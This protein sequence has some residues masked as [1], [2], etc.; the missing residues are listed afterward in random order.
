MLQR[1]R[2]LA[3]VVVLCIRARHSYSAAPLTIVEAEEA[4]GRKAL[5]DMTT[6]VT[7]DT[8]LRWY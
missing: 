2:W 7:P 1:T 8:I 4:R 3:L 5:S 6:F